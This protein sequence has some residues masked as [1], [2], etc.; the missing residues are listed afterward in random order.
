MVTVYFIA[1]HYL[2]GYF[3]YLFIYLIF[4]LIFFLPIH[5][6]NLVLSFLLYLHQAAAGDVEALEVIHK[7]RGEGAFEFVDAQGRNTLHVAASNG[8]HNTKKIN[9]HKN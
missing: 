6:F 4:Y 5:N 7:W 2:L 8:K 3:T 1:T 9:K